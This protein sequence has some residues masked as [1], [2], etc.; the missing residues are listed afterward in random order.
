MVAVAASSVEVLP[1]GES[2]DG[3][4]WLLAFSSSVLTENERLI[5]EVARLAGENERLRARVGKLEGKL[6][7]ARRAGKR[8]AAPFSRGKPKSAP[9]RPGRRSGEEHGKHGH[10]EPPGEVDEE[11]DARL[12]PRCEC[13]GE[14]EHERTEYQYQDELPVPRPV[15][16]RFAVHIGK[17]RCCGRRHQ[18]RHPFQ[19]SDAL[20][21]AACMLGPRAVALATELNKELGLSPQK[22]ARALERFGIRV[23]AGGVVQAI[24]RQA[25]ALEPTYQALIE[26]VRASRA[27][28]PD[29][30]GWRINGQK[31]WLWAFAG[32]NVTVYLIAAGRGYEDAEQ[33]LGAD[34]SGV[35]ER[36]GWAPY[37][38]FT[39]AKHQTC[40][41]HLLRRT[42]ELIADSMA[43]QAR[44]PHAARRIL[45]DAL[46]LRDQR[47]QDV[48]DAEEFGLRV[49]ELGERTDKLLAMRPT[50]APNRRLLGHLANEREHLFTFLTEP[51]VQATNWRAEQALRPAIVNRKSWGGNRSW[52][53]A[54]TQ[55]ITMSVIR[56]AHQ[57]GIDPIELMTSAQRSQA[58][59]VSE[60][61]KLPARASP[62][63]LAA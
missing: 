33:I 20:G 9:R 8:Q 48:L 26:G 10:R 36:D 13:G 28:A 51:D 22:T 1:A 7:E 42:G 19:T 54:R 52:D 60:L 56:T 32:E 61:I 18:G 37:R 29:E 58:P 57:Q 47:D 53:G 39:T 27:V 31:A 2:V 40:A 23:T 11:L 24:A 62:T 45:K 21:A 3:L 12:A 46:A 4:R 34:Y 43:G 25:R 49:T 17:C 41:A 50:H 5:G 44:V 35:L 16:R 30:T 59:A 63:S 15:R 55:Q 14:I 38:R 6:E